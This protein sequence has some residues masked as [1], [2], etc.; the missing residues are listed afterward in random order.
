MA[1]LPQWATL[2]QSGNGRW[3]LLIDHHV[4]D[5]HVRIDSTGSLDGM[6]RL[7]AAVEEFSREVA[8]A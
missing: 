1:D 5:G 3:R 8:N 7:V 2:T 6:R 4:A